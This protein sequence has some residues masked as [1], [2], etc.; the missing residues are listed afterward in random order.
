MALETQIGTLYQ[1]RRMGWGGRWEGVSK[2]RGY[3]YIYLCMIHV[4]V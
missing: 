3:I 1:P 4:E 2:E